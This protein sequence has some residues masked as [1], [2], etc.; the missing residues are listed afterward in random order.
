MKLA[1]AAD[2]GGFEMKPQII[3]LLRG[4]DYEVVDFGKFYANRF[5]KQA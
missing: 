2:H 1:I 4:A 3:K 5:L